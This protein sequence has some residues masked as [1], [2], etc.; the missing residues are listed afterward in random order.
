MTFGIGSANSNS[1]IA[2]FMQAST[3]NI[4]SSGPGSASDSKVSIISYSN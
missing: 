2:P 3:A 4:T 1:S